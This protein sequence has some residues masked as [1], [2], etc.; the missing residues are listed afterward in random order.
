MRQEG[1]MIYEQNP[2]LM[3]HQDF[4]FNAL[5]LNLRQ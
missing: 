1:L 5:I 3:L 2:L 4:H